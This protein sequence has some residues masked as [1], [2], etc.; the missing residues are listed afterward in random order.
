MAEV[1]PQ[2]P[3]LLFAVVAVISA[4]ISLFLPETEGVGLPDT[5]EESEQVG[6]VGVREVCQCRPHLRAGEEADTE[7]D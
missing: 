3:T 5:L 1:S 7:A 6:L 4:A 2:L